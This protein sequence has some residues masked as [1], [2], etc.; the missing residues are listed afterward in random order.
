MSADASTILAALAQVAAERQ[1]RLADAELSRR[2]VALKAYQQ[3][4]FAHT[5]AD[6][7]AHPRHGPAARFFLD[8][9]YGPQDFTERDAQFARIVP[10]TVRLFPQEIVVTVDALARLHALSEQ[11]DT[12]MARQLADSPLDAA[13]YV[14]AWQ[15]TGQP[16]RR[17]QQLMLVLDLGQ[18]LDRYTSQRWMRQSLKLMRTPARAAGL[19]ALQAFLE[20]GFDTFAGMRGAAAFLAEVQRRE[21]SLIDWLFSAQALA[22]VLRGI[23]H[24]PDATGQLP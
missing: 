1:V 3:R 18:R 14:L 22:A 19:A 24:V 5:H 2:V 10:A 12:A 23:T 16:D 13:G 17:L 7:L 8:E 15:A 9:L 21:Q 20:R 4:R 11:L 6:T